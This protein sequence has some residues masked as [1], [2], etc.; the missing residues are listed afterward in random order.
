M[1]L[2]FRCWTDLPL[3][4]PAPNPQCL[5]VYSCRPSCFLGVP[6]SHVLEP[7]QGWQPSSPLSR[8]STEGQCG[9]RH[10][11][12]GWEQDQ[13]LFLSPDGPQTCLPYTK[14]ML[15][16]W[17][18]CLY[19]SRTGIPSTL[20]V[21]GLQTCITACGLCSGGHGTQ[22]FVHARQA[23]YQLSCMSRPGSWF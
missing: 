6:Y 12:T 15:N 21:L 10:P 3:L 8:E 2:R 13:T 4:Q 22:G 5:S 1:V 19:A 7:Q 16:S 11:T 23:V 14:M 17:T 20:Q 18:L 9:T